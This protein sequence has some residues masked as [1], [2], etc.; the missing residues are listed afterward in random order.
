[1]KLFKSM[2]SFRTFLFPLLFGSG[3]FPSSGAA[4]SCADLALVLAIDSSGS[5][6]AQD[7]STQQAGYATA[8][9]D[10]R[11][12]AALAAAGVVDVAVVFWGDEEMAPQVLPWRRIADP[13][14][15]TGL[16]AAIMGTPRRVTGDTGIGRGLWTALDLLEESEACAA[17][18]IVNVSG[19]GKES[20][21]PRPRHRLSLAVARERAA[22]MGVTVNALAITV[23]AGDLEGWY[24][25]RLITGP[26][27]FVVT[28]TSFDAFG[29]AIIRKLAREIALPALAAAET[30]KERQP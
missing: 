30:L 9:T 5:I 27:A 11:V 1:M 24:R 28:A 12:Q 10:R 18:R 2:A 7:F 13:D 23:E 16:A 29:E 3:V 15:A 22:E 4:F 20:H 8:F 25:S 14:D 19:D 21:G 6:N 26:D 17:R